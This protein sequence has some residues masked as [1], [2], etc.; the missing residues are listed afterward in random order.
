MVAL[1]DSITDGA[2]STADANRRWP[3]YL[4]GRLSACSSTAGVLNEGISGNRITAGI[5]G[6]PS[7]LDRLERDV[8]SQP[9][10]RTVILFEGVNDLSWGG[11]TGDQVIDGMKADRAAGPRPRDAGDRRDRGPVPGVGRLVDRGQGGRPAAG[12]RV[13]PRLRRR[14]R[15]VRRLRQ[16]GPE[17]GRPHPVRRRVRL[18]RPSASQRHRDESVRRRGGPGHPRR[19]PRLPLGPRR[20]TPYRPTRKPAATAR[21]I[22]STVTNTGPTAVTQVSTRLDLPTAGPPNRPAARGPAPSPRAT[23]PPSPGR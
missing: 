23:A 9:D 2:S 1:G 10:A 3:D 20:L 15:R 4:A 13:R 16:G 19:G 18:G 21:E 22:T 5:D 12:Q 17:P 11:A 14:L 7:A 8:L 6:N